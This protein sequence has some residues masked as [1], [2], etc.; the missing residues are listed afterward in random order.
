MILKQYE[1]EFFQDL[2]QTIKNTYD[3]KFSYCINKARNKYQNNYYFIIND[4]LNIEICFEIQNIYATLAVQKPAHRAM[5]QSFDNRSITCENKVKNQILSWLTILI[6]DNSK[7][8]FN[9]KEKICL[10]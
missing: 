1:H 9:K 4:D 8:K 3:V 2:Q 5:R 10:F 7:I 6:N